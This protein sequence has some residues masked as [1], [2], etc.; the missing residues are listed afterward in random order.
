MT[1]QL[2][3]KAQKCLRCK[4]V[5]LPRNNEKPK[6]CASCKS[7]LWD[8]PRQRK[9]YMSKD[10]KRKWKPILSTIALAAFLAIALTVAPTVKVS[11]AASKS[12]ASGSGGGSGG[13]GGSTHDSG[14]GSSSSDSGSK[15]DSGG[16]GSD[17]KDSNSKTVDDGFTS[18]DGPQPTFDIGKDG[19]PKHSTIPFPG[20]ISHP[21]GPGLEDCGR[22]VHGLCNFHDD[23]HDH[24]H[25]DHDHVDVIHK[26]VVVHDNNNH[27]QSIIIIQ[28][29]TTGACIVTA[30]QINNT[31]H[32]VE[33]LLNQ[34]NSLTIL[35]GN[36]VVDHVHDTA[37]A[38]AT[39]KAG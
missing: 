31:P 4:H 21:G 13:G 22:F 19:K 26:T 25:H 29:P 34:C 33:D 38:T 20:V 32:I 35:S 2:T 30:E 16:S 10:G 12:A 15:S 28:N 6:V 39:A 23:H 5:W 36:N 14:G 24:H 37:T 8:T 17:S 3:V 1:P 9:Y 7:T 27:E 18:K 11:Y